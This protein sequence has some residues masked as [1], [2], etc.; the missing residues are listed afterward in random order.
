[1]GGIILV[2]NLLF[3]VN[4]PNKDMNILKAGNDFQISRNKIYYVFCIIFSA[5]SL[6]TVVLNSDGTAVMWELDELN[7]HPLKSLFLTGQIFQNLLL[8]TF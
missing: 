5:F 1:M 7:C 2:I 8:R 3:D 6:K 4:S